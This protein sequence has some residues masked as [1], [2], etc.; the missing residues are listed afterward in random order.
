MIAQPLRITGVILAGGQGSRLNYEDKPLL[1]LGGKPIIE[2]IIEN[3]KVQVAELL[4][5]VNRHTEKYAQFRIPII[6]D[7]VE[8]YVGPLAGVLSAMKW[9]KAHGHDRGIVA[10]FPGDVPWFPQDIVQRVATKMLA[11][12]SETGWLRT[13]GQYQPLF[14]LWSMKLHDELETALRQHVYSPM[15]FILSTR[16]VL[17]EIDGSSTEH[18]LNINSPHDLDKARLHIGLLPRQ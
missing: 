10:C 16:H 14:S 7:C 6:G 17:L 15:E 1:D 12:D 3:A 13:D 4:L 5:N 18:F 2:Y 8:G 9:C 11:N